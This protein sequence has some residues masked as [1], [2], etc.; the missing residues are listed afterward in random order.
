MFVLKARGILGDDWGSGSPL[1]LPVDVGTGGLSRSTFTTTE[2]DVE[3][4]AISTLVAASDSGS[5]GPSSAES[6]CTELCILGTVVVPCPWIFSFL[7]FGRSYDGASD[8][9]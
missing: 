9:G 2:Q 5:V 3:T 1:P 6:R 7:E 4:S 8:T